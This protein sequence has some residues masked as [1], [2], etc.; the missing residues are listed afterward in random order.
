MP[1]SIADIA[2]AAATVIAAAALLLNWYAFRANAKALQANATATDAASYTK[3]ADRIDDAYDGFRRVRRQYEAGA[4]M[5]PA[6]LRY[7]AERLMAVI[8][9][10]CHL[11][12]SG[13]LLHATRE[14]VGEYLDTILP[15]EYKSLRRVARD[16]GGGDPYRY[17]RE[18]GEH[19]QNEEIVR[20]FPP[21]GVP[22][23]LRR[24]EG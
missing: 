14:M 9:D 11:Y 23:A 21:G 12:V 18:F 5:G 3:L 17:I 16:P 22:R 10:S 15:L 13:L 8:A 19:R 1:S 24:G 7:A 20:Q 4:A 6:E 2:T